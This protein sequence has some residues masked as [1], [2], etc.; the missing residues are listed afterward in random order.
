LIPTIAL[1][2]TEIAEI[3]PQL[4]YRAVE[5]GDVAVGA[6][7]RHALHRRPRELGEF[8]AFEPVGHPQVCLKQTLFHCSTKPC[9]GLAARHDVSV[10]TSAGLVLQTR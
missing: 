7:L 5:A 8:A 9:N 10:T 4:P 1:L 3:R 2:L 6:R